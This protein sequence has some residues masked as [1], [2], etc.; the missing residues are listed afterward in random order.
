MYHDI[1]E[2]AKALPNN[3]NEINTDTNASRY[4][5]H[6]IENSTNDASGNSEELWKDVERVL[7]QYENSSQIV[8]AQNANCKV[9]KTKISS[10]NSYLKNYFELFKS[11]KSA[12]EQVR[13]HK[14]AELNSITKV[15]DKCRQE[16]D[17]KEKLVKLEFSTIVSNWEDAL[18][19]DIKHLSDKCTM[20]CKKLATFTKCR[21]KTTSNV[22]TDTTYSNLSKQNDAQ[23]KQSLAELDNLLVIKNID[24]ARMKQMASFTK[25]SLW[26][27]LPSLSYDLQKF[28]ES[29]NLIIII[30]NDINGLH[31]ALC[32]N[33][34]QSELK[35]G[36]QIQTLNADQTNSAF[37]NYSW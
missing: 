9:Y 32:I 34:N 19:E 29:L 35:S 20:L 21:T 30:K 25:V 2:A 11:S 23:I 14:Q 6:N 27:G 24:G 28:R 36:H 1:E 7:Q 16:I 37:S 4:K 5:N 3:N 31:N 12:L 18:I 26:L 33:I 17:L 15:F 8:S 10:L 22:N 13:S